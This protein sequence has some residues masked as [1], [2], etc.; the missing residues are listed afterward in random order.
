MRVA[1]EWLYLEQ[2]KESAERRWQAALRGVKLQE[3][4][5]TNERGQVLMNARS[6]GAKIERI[7]ISS[8]EKSRRRQARLEKISRQIRNGNGK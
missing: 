3:P 2:Q 8:Q 1:L 4:H 7:K 5:Q 6:L